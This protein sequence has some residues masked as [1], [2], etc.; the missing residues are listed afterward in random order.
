MIKFKN[1]EITNDT[2][3]TLNFLMDQEILAVSA[4]RIARIVKEVSSIVESKNSAEEMI[5]KK[6]VIYDEE[7][8]AVPVK[9]EKG[10]IIPN[11]VSLKDSTLFTKEMNDLMN[12]ENEI[13][14]SKIK[15]EDLGL[16]KIKPID[17]LNIDFIFE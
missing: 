2:V 15:F 8:K 9:D 6:W 1:S 13:N 11:L 14:F 7:G 3:K 5:Y 12:F 4:F 16:T 10:E 17:I